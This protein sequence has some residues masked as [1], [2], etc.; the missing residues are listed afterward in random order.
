M[1]ACVMLVVLWLVAFPTNPLGRALRRLLVDLPAERL[2]GVTPGKAAFY[3]A[4]GTAGA[5][6]FWLFES[7][8]L[9]LFS[10]M[11]PDLIVWFTMFDVSVFLDVF[12]L[13]VAVAARA[14]V[15]I[16]AVALVGQVQQVSSRIVAKVAGRDR[17]PPRSRTT[18]TNSPPSDDGEPAGYGFAM[19]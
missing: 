11:A 18:R 3:C 2:G 14:R 19:A 6:L 5:I 10:L 15:R 9:R 1:L 13:T 16:V 7:E 4:L 17:R 12:L 8:G